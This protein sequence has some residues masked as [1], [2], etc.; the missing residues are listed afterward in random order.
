MADYNMKQYI[1][2]KIVSAVPAVRID[3]VIYTYDGPVPR[4]MNREEGYK[5]LP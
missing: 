1:G 5:V 3:G 2:T 4:S